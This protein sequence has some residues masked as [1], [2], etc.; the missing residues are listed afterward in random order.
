MSRYVW[1]FLV[2]VEALQGSE[3][4][5]PGSEAQLQVCIP[6]EQL[7]SGLED[8]DRYLAS[9]EYKRL[10]LSIARRY[11]LEDDTEEFPADY[12][13]R[14]LRDAGRTNTPGTA[15]VFASEESSIC[16]PGKAN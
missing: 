12:L 11:D 6:G 10:D 2:K 14:D 16:L 15:C 4:L 3:M 1:M 9:E 7:E 8:L 13:E 5:T